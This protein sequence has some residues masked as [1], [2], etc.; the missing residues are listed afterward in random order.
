MA[1]SARA[2]RPAISGTTGMAAI[3][4]AAERIQP[5]RSRLLGPRIRASRSTAPRPSN[6]PLSGLDAAIPL[7]PRGVGTSGRG[8]T[9][10]VS[11]RAFLVIALVGSLLAGLCLALAATVDSTLL[12]VAGALFVVAVGVAR[13]GWLWQ[14]DLRGWL[15]MMAGL[16]LVVVIAYGF[17]AVV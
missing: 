3:S 2:H 15:R 1:A 13:E 16:A 8:Y 10:V 12:A 17:S 4:A 6:S 9:P 14:G 11:G 7:V 5:Q